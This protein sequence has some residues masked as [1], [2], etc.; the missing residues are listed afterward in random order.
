MAILTVSSQGAFADALKSAGAGDTI[1]LTPGTYGELAIGKSVS[2]V[3][4][5]SA[6][7][8]DPAVVNKLTLRGAT[9]IELR[10]LT[11]DYDPSRSNSTPFWVEGGRGIDIVDVTFEGHD[12][13]GFGE[14]VGLR[15]KGGSDITVSQ[16]EIS[17]FRNGIYASNGTDVT[18]LGNDFREMSNDGMLLGGMN[19]VLIQ[20]NDFRD[21]DSPASRKHKDGIQFLTSASEAGSRDVVIR[22]N[23]IV[24]PEVSHGIFLTNTVY[25]NGNGSSYHRNV[26]IEDNLV[27]GNQVHGI[28]VNHGAGVTIRD[29]VVEQIPGGSNIPL[30][31]V[32]RYSYDVLIQGNEVASVPVPQNGT[33]TVVGNDTNSQRQHWYGDAGAP[34]VAI[35]GGSAPAPAPSEPAPSVPAPPVSAPSE[36]TPGP[37]PEP[38]APNGGGDAILVRGVVQNG[39]ENYRIGANIVGDGTT[40]FRVEDIDFSDGDVFVFSNFATETFRHEKGGNPIDI[41]NGGGSA[42]INSAI[43]FQEIGANSPA[44]SVVASGNDVTVALQHRDGVAEVVFADLAAAFRAADNPGLF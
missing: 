5:T 42:K 29:N 12:I 30:I 6:N 24:N 43:D 20:G 41:W 21:M 13:G 15:L 25:N 8:A 37:A 1:A 7:A 39:V 16:S 34:K 10:D 40:R 26:L 31:N 28:S 18:L 38:E 14:G 19:G 33:W 35:P 27:L 9:N 44:V 22:D 17:G 11:F 4:I 36:P 32:S 3:T 23:V 2:N